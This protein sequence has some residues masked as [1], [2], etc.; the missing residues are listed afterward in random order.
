[1]LIDSVE[2]LTCHS[3]ISRTQTSYLQ[4]QID[5]D[6]TEHDVTMVYCINQVFIEHLKLILP[7][8]RKIGYFSDGCAVQA[9]IKTENIYTTYIS[10][11]LILELAQCGIFSLPPTENPLVMELEEQ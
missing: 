5:I 11:R 9:S 3:Y 1:M 6:D 10:I 8:I 2:K 7:N 4:K